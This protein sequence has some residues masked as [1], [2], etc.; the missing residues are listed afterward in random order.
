MTTVNDQMER[1]LGAAAAGDVKQ[2][3]RNVD[4]AG[5]DAAIGQHKGLLAGKP[6][7]SSAASIKV[8]RPIDQIY[9]H[10]AN[11]ALARDL[12]DKRR[13]V[14]IARNHVILAEIGKLLGEHAENVA[15]IAL[16][17]AMGLRNHV[18]QKILETSTK[19]LLAGITR[20]K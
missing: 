16:T 18:G 10:S 6:L 3:M 11:D 13:D 2:A 14:L 17:E 19:A 1:E 9:S 20:S 15:E 5:G 4:A 7:A 12:S 8:E